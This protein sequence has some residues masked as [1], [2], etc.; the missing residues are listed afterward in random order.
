MMNYIIYTKEKAN[1]VYYKESK[2]AYHYSEL[3]GQTSPF[4][5][6]IDSTFNQ[7][8]PT[9]PVYFDII[10]IAVMGFV[11]ELS[12][13]TYFIFKMTAPTGQFGLLVSVIL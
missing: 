12:K 8:C 2:G 11:R 1:K 13:E 5:K 7:H 3:A 4:A 10:C 9:R 6:R